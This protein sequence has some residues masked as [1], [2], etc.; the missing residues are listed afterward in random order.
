MQISLASLY[1]LKYSYR[2]HNEPAMEQGLRLCEMLIFDV[3][4]LGFFL[5]EAETGHF[6][7]LTSTA[8]C[9]RCMQCT[10]LY[11]APARDKLIN[12]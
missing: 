4:D 1:I 6:S 3:M 5:Q 8:L 11:T 7:Y 2:Q 10:D 9:A 12:G